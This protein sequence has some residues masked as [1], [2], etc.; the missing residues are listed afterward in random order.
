VIA[1]ER[2]IRKE[3]EPMKTKPLLL[4][5]SALILL[6]T[7]ST[8]ARADPVVLTLPAN[9]VVQAGGS[10]GVIGTL[11]NQGAPP[12]NILLWSINLS[13]ALLTFDDTGFQGS[14]LVLN[15]LETFGPTNFFDVFANAALAPGNYAGTF[16]VM[17]TTRNLNVTQTFVITVTPGTQAVPEPASM[18][19]LVSGVSGLLLARRRRERGP[20]A[21]GVELRVGDEQ[22][23]SAPGAPVGARLECV[24]VL[25]SERALRALLPQNAVLLGR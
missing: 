3:A 12:F 10:V 18:I 15:A 9:V 17:D 25:A 11:E 19:L 22:L 8:I 24:V 2:K 5:V 4:S 6:A 16:T 21:A 23:G 13:N 14:P 20:A 1:L 7:L